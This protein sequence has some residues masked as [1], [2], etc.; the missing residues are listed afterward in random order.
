M[1]QKKRDEI[2]TETHLRSSTAD[3][4]IDVD[5]EPDSAENT[6][7]DPENGALNTVNE[8][9]GN[10]HDTQM[11]AETFK[12]ADDIGKSVAEDTADHQPSMNSLA[13][14]ANKGV[15]HHEDERGASG[16]RLADEDR[17]RASEPDQPNDKGE[18]VKPDRQDQDVS[19]TDVSGFES[20][21]ELAAKGEVDYKNDT[22]ESE[23]LPDDVDPNAARESDQFDEDEGRDAEPGEPNVSSSIESANDD[24]SPDR[25]PDA[26]DANIDTGSSAKISDDNGEVAR[27]TDAKYDDSLKP[28]AAISSSEDED[29][30]SA[31]EKRTDVLDSSAENDPIEQHTDIIGEDLS[32]LEPKKKIRFVKAALTIIIVAALFWGFFIFDNKSNIKSAQNVKSKE[33]IEASSLQASQKNLKA[34][35][36]PDD[37]NYIYHAK[38]DEISALRDTLLHKNEEILA[39]KK[40]Y[41]SGIEELE[42]E[43]LDELQ[44][45][46]N[47][48]FLEAIENKRIEFTL[49]TIQRRLAYIQALDRP[50]QWVFQAA[51]E[52]LY[53]KRKALMDIQ[54]AEVA[55]GIDM[56]MH[57]RHMN[58]ALNK[59]RPTA[60]K[61]AIDMT[62]ARLESIESIWQRIQN[63]N[64]AHASPGAHSKNQIIFEQICNGNYS[65]L[66][67]LSELSVDSAKCI[68]EME[69]SDLFLNGLTEISPSAARH[70]FQWKGNWICLNG[71][72]ALSPRVATHLFE[73]E[74]RW[75]SLNGLTDFPPEIGTLLL[76]WGGNQLELMGL[77]YTNDSAGEIGIKYLAQW[78]RSGGKLYVPKT[79]RKKIDEINGNDA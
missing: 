62:D 10:S 29:E 3:D 70:L 67:E 25:E 46:A 20:D 74:G 78:E 71:F 15:V 47:V 12:N 23:A 1:S 8:T 28:A 37:P 40:R 27:L 61:L 35:I 76:Q 54:V 6:P 31:A 13:A 48:T 21:P 66:A 19:T 56:N 14:A 41:Q 26:L 79:I 52:L 55:S 16:E 5:Q 50:A 51:E 22:P 58:I 73:W 9:S 43:I 34:A 18:P 17:H 75:I 44:H 39:L 24:L 11:V 59:Y 72:R 64:L 60:D 38:I 49:L 36:Q 7:K 33:A 32:E 45:S 68:V 53:I 42:K 69:G 57:V 77:R 4:S 2:A 30:D 65:R 63:K